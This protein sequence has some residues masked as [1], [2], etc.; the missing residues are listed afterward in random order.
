M[1]QKILFKIRKIQKVTHVD[2]MKE[3]SRLKKVNKKK[4]EKDNDNN[5]WG[6]QQIVIFDYEQKKYN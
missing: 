5:N 3:N 1:E 6:Y 2:V 4:M